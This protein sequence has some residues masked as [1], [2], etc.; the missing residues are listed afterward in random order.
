MQ[1]HGRRSYSHNLDDSRGIDT[2]ETYRLAL[3][4]SRLP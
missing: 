4:G 1:G 3:P 2:A